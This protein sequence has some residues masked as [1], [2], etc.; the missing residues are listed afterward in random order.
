MVLVSL[1][2]MSMEES[3]ALGMPSDLLLNPVACDLELLG[4]E[5]PLA[6][7][8]LPFESHSDQARSWPEAFWSQQ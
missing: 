5:I 6:W 4:H 7:L 2:L 1:G 8:M 3:L